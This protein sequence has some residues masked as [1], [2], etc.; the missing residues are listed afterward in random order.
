M[1]HKSSYSQKTPEPNLVFGEPARNAFDSGQSSSATTG[2]KMPWI[3][4]EHLALYLIINKTCKEDGIDRLTLKKDTRFLQAC[5]DYINAECFDLYLARGIERN[6]EMVHS[7]MRHRVESTN[8]N[9]KN[10]SFK[11]IFARA[12]RM[13]ERI[14]SKEDI[15]HKE[16]YPEQALPLELGV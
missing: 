12:K 10:H 13:M 6:P 1:T 7:Q 15:P 9:L 8:T 11:D 3:S 5:T 14:D 2:K 4:R 16:R